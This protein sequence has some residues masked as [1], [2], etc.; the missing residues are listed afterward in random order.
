LSNLKPGILLLGDDRPTLTVIRSMYKMGYQITLGTAH[1]RSLC[2]Q[3]RYVA[4][5]W[6]HPP[7]VG[8]NVAYIQALRNYLDNHT[9]IKVV[10]PIGENELRIFCD[11]DFQLSDDI[12]VIFAGNKTVSICLNKPRLLSLAEQLDIPTSSTISVSNYKELSIASDQLGFPCIIKPSDSNNNGLSEKAI[13]IYTK[14][15]LE[16]FKRWPMSGEQ[17][18]VQNYFRGVRHNIYF[19]ANTG[20]TVSLVEVQII[21]TD[22]SSDTGLAIRGKS[23]ELSDI[24]ASYTKRLVKNLNYNG[25]GCAQFLINQHGN[26]NF[27]ELNPRLGANIAI[28]DHC[29][30]D[31]P[32]LFAELTG[33]K[34]NQNNNYIEA[35][36]Y[37]R[38]VQY[39]WLTGELDALT[40]DYESGKDTLFK[41]IGRLFGLA[42]LSFVST[43][44]IVWHKE[45]PM[46]G[47]KQFYWV[48]RSL[49]GVLI[50]K[51]FGAFKQIYILFQKNLWGISD[52]KR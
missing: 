28:T 43:S 10:F 24:L 17:L 2:A 42:K 4:N 29:G 9:N 52:T 11:L 40:R 38:E 8:N 7:R 34:A 39:I 45:D 33:A 1:S 21:S 47:I 22:K 48:T 20:K 26:I 13:I 41:M 36:N 37:K 44:H 30:V 35:H 23:V 12:Q 5:I 6:R 46:P 50:R 49:F 32:R 14:I 16:S 51:I 18:L 3:S 15:E 31:L 25:V 19:A 27:L